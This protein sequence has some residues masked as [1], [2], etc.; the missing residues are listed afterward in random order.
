MKIK[1]IRSTITPPVK[2]SYGA[3]QKYLRKQVMKLKG[4]GNGGQQRTSNEHPLI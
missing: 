2:L 4:T 1:A 3:W